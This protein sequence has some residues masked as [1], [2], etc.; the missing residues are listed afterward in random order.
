MPTAGGLHRALL[1]GK[2]IGCD[3]VQLFT[4]SPRQW[5]ARTLDSEAIAAFSAASTESGC[6]P[7][8]AHDSYLINLASPD[9]EVREKSMKAFRDE[10]ERCEALGIDFL[11]SHPG[12]HM[13]AGEDAGIA[14]LAESLDRV[15]AETAGF[16]LKV[17]LE[18]T[19]A[20]GTTLGGSFAHFPAILSRV[21]A[22][23]R[24]VVCLDTC[25]IFDAGYDIKGSA[26]A[27]WDAFDRI[28]GIERLAV[29]HAN[30]SKFGLG[31]RRDHHADIGEG[32][33]G[34]AGFKA[35]LGDVRLHRAAPAQL[36]VIVET[37]VDTD[38]A[39]DHARNVARLREILE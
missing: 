4:S 31:S 12:A 1:G 39:T 15:H 13:G 9:P 33:I 2:T 36:P 35:F 29:I 23:E 20:K 21:Q 22:P 34:D 25:H 6:T 28:V 14:T 37:P 16:R 3:T 27:V 24:L 17:A 38:A 11:V 32:M 18:T 8:V 30:D 7:I 5:L 19:A 10:M 26:A